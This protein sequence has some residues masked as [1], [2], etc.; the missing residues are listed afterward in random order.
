MNRRLALAMSGMLGC[1]VLCAGCHS[2]GGSMYSADKFTYLSHEWQPWTVTLIDTRTGES[3]W[4]V[5]VPVGKQLVFGFREGAGPN[6][7]KP[8][9]MDWGLWEA[10]RSYGT[11]DNQLPV[12]P[13]KSRRIEPSLRPT[14]EL[15]GTP[16]PGSPF[17]AEVPARKKKAAAA[18]SIPPSS[19]DPF[20]PHRR[21]AEPA[22]QP[23]PEQAP[24][25]QP[26]PME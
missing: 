14:P 4:S 13:A 2:E 6:Q 17:V 19:G 24:E 5:D 16:L 3:L 18:G 22:P 23:A 20:A 10:G 11:R 12:P 25:A 7:F 15:P 9:M 8:D 21:P 1:G 26:D